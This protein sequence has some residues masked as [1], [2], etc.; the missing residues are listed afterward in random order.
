MSEK[1]MITDIEMPMTLS[2]NYTAGDSTAR[3]LRHMKKGKIVGQR[4]PSCSN[5]YVPPRGCCAICGVVTKDEVRLSGKATI[6][7]FT[8]VHIPIPDSPINPP[9]VAAEM[10][11]DGSDIT[12]LH[13]VSEVENEKVEIGM[14]VGPV[15]K[16]KDQWEYSFENI[17]YFKPIDEPN[18]DIDKILGR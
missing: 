16:D 8:I 13:L 18:V 2:Y 12:T 9:F 11:L 5:V 15:W 14:R 10:L 3:F 4:C 7:S 1:E 6:V 17:M